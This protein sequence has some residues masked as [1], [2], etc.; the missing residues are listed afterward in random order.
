M[1]Y[2]SIDIDYESEDLSELVFGLIREAISCDAKSLDDLETLMSRV[3]RKVRSDDLEPF[4]IE[5]FIDLE[6]ELSLILND[7]GFRNEN[8][9]SNATNCQRLLHIV[10]KKLLPFNE[11]F[12]V[13]LALNPFLPEAIAEKLSKSEFAWEE[14]GTTQAL[15]RATKNPAILTKLSKSKDNSTRYEVALNP[16]S[17]SDILEKLAKDVEISDSFWYCNQGLESFIQVAVVRNLNT[18]RAVIEGF[19]TDKYFFSEQDFV[20]SH[21][22]NLVSDG[23]LAELRTLLAK[24]A[25]L[26]LAM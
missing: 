18:P 15:A 4:E 20:K 24:E 12:E 11:N 26:R 16:C 21:G 13:V 23:G 3:I 6:D 7:T 10:H 1:K 9:G 22:W 25:S 19:L 17:P 5:T 14:D 8:A 2:K